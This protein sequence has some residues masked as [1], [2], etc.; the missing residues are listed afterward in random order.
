MAPAIPIV[1]SE[2]SQHPNQINGALTTPEHRS[3]APPHVQME[4]SW[5]SSETPTLNHISE[6]ETV[7]LPLN[8]PLTSQMREEIRMEL[9]REWHEKRKYKFC[10]NLNF[11]WMSHTDYILSINSSRDAVKSRL[12]RKFY[13]KPTTLYW[14]H[15]AQMD[16]ACPRF[17]WGCIYKEWFRCYDYE[18]KM[19]FE[20]YFANPIRITSTGP[21]AIFDILETHEYLH[22]Q[23][24]LLLDKI[25]RS[26]L[27]ESRI[28]ARPSPQNFKLFPI[29]WFP[30]NVL[31]WNTEFTLTGASY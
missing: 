26:E 14:P 21:T 7:N 1:S 5:I 16:D 24:S 22:N 10:E 3:S 8:E 25:K 23:A 20:H 4:A 15:S 2:F 12:L 19:D 31:V 17:I 13:N 6:P 29:L 28:S 27:E 11:S 9:R 18:P 30:I